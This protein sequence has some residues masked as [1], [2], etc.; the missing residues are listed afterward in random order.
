VKFWQEK[1][2]EPLFLA[3]SLENRFNSNEI[4]LIVKEAMGTTVNPTRWAFE[5]QA[6]P[7]QPRFFDEASFSENYR[8]PFEYT[9]MRVAVWEVKWLWVTVW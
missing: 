4:R 8:H 9:C 5:T 6:L 1:D 3:V 7:L 2:F